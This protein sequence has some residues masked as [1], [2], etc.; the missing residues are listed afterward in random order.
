MFQSYHLS[1]CTEVRHRFLRKVSHLWLLSEY[2]IISIIII[3]IIIII[4]YLSGLDRK[5]EKI[6][7]FLN[8]IIRIIIMFLK[9]V[10]Q[11]DYSVLIS[12]LS[13]F[14]QLEVNPQKENTSLL[15]FCLFV[16][17]DVVVVF[18]LGW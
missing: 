16:V 17:V 15:L 14:C 11:V 7:Y 18:G 1:L 3:I 10:T 2:I 13:H 4:I 12:Y 5:V 6:E 8:L 9:V